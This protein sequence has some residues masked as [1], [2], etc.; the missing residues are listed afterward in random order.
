VTIQIVLSAAITAAGLWCGWWAYWIIDGWRQR[1]K[2]AG[3]VTEELVK[4]RS[5]VVAEAKR[6]E[7]EA[8][9]E[10]REG[11]SC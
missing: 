7:E 11:N 2:L 8:G 1:R 3:I 10:N 6:N 5:E 9:H 4:Y